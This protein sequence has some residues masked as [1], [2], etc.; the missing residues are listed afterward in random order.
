MFGF[1]LNAYLT[2]ECQEAWV[3]VQQ[4]EDLDSDDKTDP[5]S[6]GKGRQA[7]GIW[8]CLGYEWMIIKLRE[9]FCPSNNLS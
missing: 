1:H 7:A 8:A 5:H 6:S 9:A 2:P 4:L 3:C